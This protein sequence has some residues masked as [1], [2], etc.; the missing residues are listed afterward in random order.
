MNLLSVLQQMVR[1]PQV[2]FDTHDCYVKLELPIEDIVLNKS[3]IA[4]QLKS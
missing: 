3:M 4:I 1:L 2:T